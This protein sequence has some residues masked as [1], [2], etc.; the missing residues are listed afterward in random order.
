MLKAPQDGDRESRALT[1]LSAPG[2]GAEESG[3]LG[4]TAAPRD[5]DGG[6]GM[7]G[8]RRSA[9]SSHS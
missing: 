6:G 8:D 5:G 4:P 2:V 7:P 9:P 3:A 1:L